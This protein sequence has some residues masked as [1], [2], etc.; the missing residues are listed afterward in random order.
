MVGRGYLVVGVSRRG[1]VVVASLRWEVCLWCLI[2]EDVSV[3]FVSNGV[4][5][6]VSR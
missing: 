5:C 2:V 1:V 6:N 4:E 3:G